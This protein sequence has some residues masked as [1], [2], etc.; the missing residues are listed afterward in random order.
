V[1]AG[2]EDAELTGLL[3]EKHGST[4]QIVDHNARPKFVLQGLLK[5][6]QIFDVNGPHAAKKL[7]HLVWLQKLTQLVVVLGR[8]GWFVFTDLQGSTADDEAERCLHDLAP[9]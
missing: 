9:S 1:S 7:E 3:V 5:Q 2:R 4:L 8:H 6:R